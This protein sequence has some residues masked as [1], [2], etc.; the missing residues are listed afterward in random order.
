MNNFRH[1]SISIFEKLKKFDLNFENHRLKRVLDDL[2]HSF[3]VVDRLFLLWNFRS[4]F[5]GY[6][7]SFGEA[8]ELENG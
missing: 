2:N 1:M 6:E 7:K 5:F 8:L 4:S 3:M